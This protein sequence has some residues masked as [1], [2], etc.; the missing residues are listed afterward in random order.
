LLAVGAAFLVASRGGSVLS[1]FLAS[2]SDEILMLKA[3]GVILVVAGRC[4]S[5]S[6]GAAPP[7]TA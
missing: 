6:L 3:L 4:G 2:P 1:R 5:A 7:S